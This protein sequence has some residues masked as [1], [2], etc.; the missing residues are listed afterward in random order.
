MDRVEFLHSINCANGVNSHLDLIMS[1]FDQYMLL[2]NIIDN[3]TGTSI[4]SSDEHHI[5]FNVEYMDG[6]STQNTFQI[7]TN[8]PVVELYQSIYSISVL[9]IDDRSL[10]ITISK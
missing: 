7:I 1:F 8:N 6:A 9:V 10:N 3:I 5:G 4:I 2:Y